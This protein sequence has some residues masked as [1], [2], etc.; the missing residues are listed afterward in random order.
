MTKDEKI[1][2]RL[3]ADYIK[4]AEKYTVL[5]VFL[6]GSQNYNLDYEGS[7]IDTKAIVIPSLGDIVLNRKPVSTTWIL[8]SNEHIDVKDIRLMHEC[9]RKQNINFVEVLFTKYR[10]LNPEFEMLYERMFIH[11]EEIARYN[12]VAAV[13]CILG[14]MMEKRKAL[15]HPYPTIID[16]IEKYGYDPKQLHHI[17]RNHDFLL[18]YVNGFSYRECLNPTLREWLIDIK[19]LPPLYTLEEAIA[20]ADETMKVAKEIEQKYL[21]HLEES[22]YTSSESASRIMN[23][24]LLDV[25]KAS[26]KSEL[27]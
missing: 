7:D 24:C 4:V 1:F 11:A 18:K 3:R 26:L 6:Q 22:N 23:E 17:M 20:L 25:M 15:C 19:R 9:F 10:M 13:K 21:A 2:G 16:R 8:E 12:E 5:G 27:V 14:Q